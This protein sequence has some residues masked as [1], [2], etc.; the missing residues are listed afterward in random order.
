MRGRSTAAIIPAY[1]EE[2]IIGSVVL[3]TKGYVGDN[4]AYMPTG[5][6]PESGMIN[7]LAFIV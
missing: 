3:K 2:L 5:Y 6:T 7:H 1:N 4:V